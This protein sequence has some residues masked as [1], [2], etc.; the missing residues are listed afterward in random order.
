MNFEWSTPIN[1]S[2]LILN[3]VVSILLAAASAYFGSRAALRK[4]RMNREREA[5]ETARQ[6]AMNGV[7]GLLQSINTA[8]SPYWWGFRD[9]DNDPDDEMRG[10]MVERGAKWIGIQAAP[11]VS[12]V[13][14]SYLDE[15]EHLDPRVVSWVRD[16][17]RPL[18]A[19]RSSPQPLTNAL[20]HTA[21]LR[22]THTIGSVPVD[23]P[24]ARV[25]P[26]WFEEHPIT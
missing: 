25:T 8:A 23:R 7:P 14:D 2:E 6:E 24:G 20:I 5:I 1:A 12:K 19:I 3:I 21:G 22:V 15:N 26:Q 16:L 11:P 17:I 13:I 4:E 18:E 9:A 10:H